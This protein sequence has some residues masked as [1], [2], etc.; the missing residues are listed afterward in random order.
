VLNLKRREEGT[1]EKF[2]KE[3]KKR[4]MLLE[5]AKKNRRGISSDRISRSRDRNRNSVRIINNRAVK[6]P[7]IKTRII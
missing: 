4:K 1:S 6:K 7:I 5:A 2:R 3:K